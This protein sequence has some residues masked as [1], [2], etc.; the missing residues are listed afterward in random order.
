MK[1]YLALS[2]AFVCLVR[3]DDVHHLRGDAQKRTAT[4]MPVPANDEVGAVG[5]EPSQKQEVAETPKGT[6]NE[7]SPT[8]AEEVA[9]V[10]KE[11]ETNGN[12]KLPTQ[13]TAKGT[14][15]EAQVENGKEAG[16][17]AKEPSPKDTAAKPQVTPPRTG[18]HEP[19]EEAVYALYY[20]EEE[21]WGYDYGPDGDIPEWDDR[22]QWDFDDYDYDY[23]DPEDFEEPVGVVVK[24][25]DPSDPSAPSGTEAVAASAATA[26]AA[27]DDL[28]GGHTDQEVHGA[29]SILEAFPSSGFEFPTATNRVGTDRTS[30]MPREEVS[31][32]LLVK[33]LAAALVKRDEQ[34]VPTT[35]A[36]MSHLQHSKRSSAQVDKSRL[37]QILSDR[38]E[39][40]DCIDGSQLSSLECLQV[41]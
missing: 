36:A 34:K 9:A 14:E 3:G 4:E 8:P 18:V 20:P 29:K 25:S 16:V 27:D 17:V 1:V 15:H 19:D 38:L 35:A 13:E 6:E 31:F 22:A 40:T 30:Q 28:G 12:D 32:Q 39:C 33:Y 41:L 23:P 2:L 10:G 26:G 37:D 11:P 24:E 7:A 5:K 21:E